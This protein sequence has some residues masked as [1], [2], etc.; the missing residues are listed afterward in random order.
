MQKPK[1]IIYTDG[2]C[3]PNPGR[4][5]WGAVVI[6]PGERYELWGNDADTTN[7]RMELIA[8]IES[9]GSLKKPSKVIIYTDSQYLQKGINEW[10]PR[11][12]KKNWRTTSGKVAN[13]DLWQA[14]LE[15]GKTHDIQWGWVKGHAGD[16]NN[17]RA[18]FLAR[19]A[20][21]G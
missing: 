19:K 10:L 1:V 12:I 17:Q 20:R 11:W 5:G 4:G 16:R 9:L 13:Q 18:D 2:A 21:S 3:D 8:A 15:T 6:T 7:N 14:L